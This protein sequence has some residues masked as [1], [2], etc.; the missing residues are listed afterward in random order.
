MVVAEGVESPEEYWL[1]RQLGL[2]YMQGFLFGQPQFEPRYGPVKLL[3]SRVW[4]LSPTLRP[5]IR[6]AGVLDPP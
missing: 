2:R 6:G 4:R 1:L 5:P 3:P